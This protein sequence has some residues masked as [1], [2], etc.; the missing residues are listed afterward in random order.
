MEN[1]KSAT[2]EAPDPITARVRLFVADKGSALSEFLDME[3]ETKI[4]AKRWHSLQCGNTK[5]VPADML[6]AMCATWPQHALWLVSG[7]HDSGAGHLSPMPP[8]TD[9]TPDIHAR[10]IEVFRIVWKGS[11]RAAEEETGIAARRWRSVCTRVQK[12]SLDMV[13][14][15]I[16]ARPRY[17]AWLMRGKAELPPQTTPKRTGESHK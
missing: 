7:R 1:N 17:A 10:F 2:Q 5:A 15:V 9:E 14:A 8:K 16:E 12:P 4:V 11:F 13:Q 6:D 3:K